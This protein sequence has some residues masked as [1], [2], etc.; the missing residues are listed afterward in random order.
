MNSVLGFFLILKYWQEREI[1]SQRGAKLHVHVC[2][3]ESFLKI[4]FKLLAHLG[5]VIASFL[6][7]IISC[8]IKYMNGTCISRESLETTRCWQSFWF[9]FLFYKCETNYLFVKGIFAWT[10]KIKLNKRNF[11]Y[12]FYFTTYYTIY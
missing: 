5:R 12:Q 2:A 7:Y 9:S 11:L 10:Q 1:V 6:L 3:F 4:L 8:C